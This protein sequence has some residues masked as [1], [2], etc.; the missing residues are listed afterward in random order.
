MIEK[1][2]EVEMVLMD[3]PEGYALSLLTLADKLNEVIDE[4]NKKQRIMFPTS[5]DTMLD[6]K[7]IE[8]LKRIADTLE[9]IKPYY[10]ERIC[11]NG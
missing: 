11:N 10:K 2:T 4:L 6:A 3:A 5:I 7:T 1:L 9:E 8:S